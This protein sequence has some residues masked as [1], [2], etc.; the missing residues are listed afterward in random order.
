MLQEELSKT[1]RK[2]GLCSRL[3]IL[4]VGGQVEAKTSGKIQGSCPRMGLTELL[5]TWGRG[6]WQR[7][8]RREDPILWGRG[9]IHDG[10]QEE[11][12]GSLRGTNREAA[13]RHGMCGN[14]PMA[15]TTGTTPNQG[16]AARRCGS[17]RAQ[18][19]RGQEAQAR[20]RQSPARGYLGSHRPTQP[21]ALLA[22]PAPFRPADP[23]VPGLVTQFLFCQ[24]GSVTVFRCT[25]LLA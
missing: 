11:D 24:D 19:N 17:H 25:C 20:Q 10:P 23:A 8:R 13:R 7:W 21:S 5:P 15:P 4:W 2:S 14:S 22:D 16:E 9:T 6:W 1:A 3:C 12:K 18:G